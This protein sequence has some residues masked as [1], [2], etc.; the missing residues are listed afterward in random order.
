M[1][2]VVP[3]RA[4]PATVKTLPAPVA[5]NYV[6]RLFVAGA[7]ARSRHAVLRV[8]HLC[9]AEL[10]NR[11]DLVVIDIY[12]QPELAR[13]NQIVVTPTLIIEFPPPARRFIGSLASLTGLDVALDDGP[14]GKVTR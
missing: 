13:A 4:F 7:T 10:P 9:A 8:R 3:R 1:K 14:K 5:S 2:P 6:L 11:C 12:Q